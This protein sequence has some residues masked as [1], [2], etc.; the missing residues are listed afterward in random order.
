MGE[1]FYAYSFKAL[2]ENRPVKSDETADNYH[3]AYGVALMA[4]PPIP[5]EGWCIMTRAWGV[6]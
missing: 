1:T 4:V 2:E 6:A 3:Y 5:P